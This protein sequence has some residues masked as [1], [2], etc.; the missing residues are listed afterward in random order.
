MI[1]SAS[2]RTSAHTIGKAKTTLNAH[3]L[4]RTMAGPSFTTGQTPGISLL[5]HIV[6][7]E[8]IARLLESD[9]DASGGANRAVRADRDRLAVHADGFEQS[10]AKWEKCAC[11]LMEDGQKPRRWVIFD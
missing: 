7:S 3:T 2:I 6:Y 11:Q 1:P 9:S 5:D 8:R 10:E 4:F